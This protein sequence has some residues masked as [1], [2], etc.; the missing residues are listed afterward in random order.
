MWSFEYTQETSAEAEAVWRLWSDPP[1]W[2]R[3]DE[4]LEEVSLDGAFEFG[5]TGTLKPKGMDGFGFELTRVEVGVG[6]TDETALPGAVLRFDHDLVRDNGRLQIVQRVTM[7]GPAANDYFGELGTG[8][9]LDVPE[10]LRK[11]A[12]LAESA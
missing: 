2:P 5:S 6:Y 8:I 4:D 9:V 3:W 12:A 10:A 1:S 7:E 11:L